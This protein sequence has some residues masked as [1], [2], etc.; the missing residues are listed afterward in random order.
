MI[1]N[2]RNSREKAFRHKC[3]TNHKYAPKAL[4]AKGANAVS[5]FMLCLERLGKAELIES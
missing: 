4:G 5:P 2:H 1:I 3:S